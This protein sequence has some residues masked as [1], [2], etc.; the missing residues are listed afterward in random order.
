MTHDTTALPPAPGA[1]QGLHSRRSITKAA[2]WS[3]PVV[4]VAAAAPATAASPTPRP[5][6]QGVARANWC[7]RFDCLRA[8]GKWDSKKS[9]V[10][11]SVGASQSTKYGVLSFS[12]DA[13]G[14]EAL[15]QSF[16][17][18][19]TY[20]FQ[21]SWH[22][23][24]SVEGWRVAQVGSGSKATGWTYRFSPT[25]AILPTIL[26]VHTPQGH[27]PTSGGPPVRLTV[28]QFRGTAVRSTVPYRDKQQIR[29]VPLSLPVGFAWDAIV[30][31][32]SPWGEAP[33]N[34][35]SQG[36]VTFGIGGTGL[37]VR[38]QA[39]LGSSVEPAE[40]AVDDVVETTGELEI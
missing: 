29:G 31:Y 35:A 16:T 37:A 7:I 18:S 32:G 9:V 24:G 20:P 11:V 30:Y 21:V 23:S 15:L 39:P 34:R 38:S 22:K 5:E 8:G 14:I 19:T 27:R 33:I 26:A 3:V 10:E 2:A 1:D 17:I 4:A 6:V 13:E 12:S 36:R 25:S 28:P 40:D